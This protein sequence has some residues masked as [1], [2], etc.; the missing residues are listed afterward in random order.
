[1]FGALC[2][3]VCCTA[4]ARAATGAGALG[5][6]D[7]GRPLAPFWA[8]FSRATSLQKLKVELNFEY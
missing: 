1:M 4:G 7:I 2:S 5:A 3:A 6:A 8:F